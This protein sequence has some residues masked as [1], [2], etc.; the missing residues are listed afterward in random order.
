MP[1]R[2]KVE[3]V[4]DQ[5]STPGDNLLFCDENKD[6]HHISGAR[7]RLCNFL[8]VG[9]KE[10]EI[11]NSSLTQCEF[12]NSYFRK[13][14]FRSVDFTGSVFYDCNFD[15]SKFQSCI[16]KYARFY[17]C[18]LDP[19]EIEQSLPAEPNLR[20][21]LARN[22]RT[23]LLNQGDKEG[24]DY[25]LDIIMSA[26]EELFYNIAWRRSSYYRDNYDLM[27]SGLYIIKHVLL[28]LSKFMW[29]YGYK[30]E[31][32][33]VTFVAITLIF[34]AV[35]WK[36]GF[37]Y[38]DTAGGVVNLSFLESL[39]FYGAAIVTSSVSNLSPASTSSK[40]A[41]V[42]ANFT[43]AIFIAILAAAVYQRIS[44]K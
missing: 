20:L 26:Q 39:Y 13:A 23:N 4:L 2:K 14:T 35:S 16:L 37:H 38:K 42:L 7:L 12:H 41:F 22:I 11:D 33:I 21:D 25:F 34:S 6:H 19:R 1:Y 27:T 9:M 24:A 43:G 44:R 8:R 17:N 36:F 15:K 29:G 28:K 10:T 3:A 31:R 40:I 18:I 30:I 5:I 32:L